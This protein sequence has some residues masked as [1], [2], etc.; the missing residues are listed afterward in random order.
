MKNE[1]L[2]KIAASYNVAEDQIPAILNAL[3]IKT[4]DPN[5]IQLKGFGQVCQLMKEGTSLERAAQAVTAEAK[6]KATAK[7][8][9]EPSQKLSVTER[10]KQ[11]REIGLRHRISDERIPEILAA[12]KL[13][14]EVLTDEQ[15]ERFRD[16]CKLLESGVALN[17]ACQSTGKNIPSEAKAKSVAKS[18]SASTA[19]SKAEGQGDAELVV[20]AKNDIAA[21]ASQFSESIPQD[22][23]EA[24]AQFP[25]EDAQ[26]V[27]LKSPGIISDAIEVAHETTEEGL[28]NF[29]QQEWYDEYSKGVR[30][31]DFGRQVREMLAQGKSQR[32]SEDS[33]T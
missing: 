20:A 28:T 19:I 16:V 31:P 33:S 6:A 21:P 32:N 26:A 24:I 10:E 23:R 29:V 2:K 15:V 9:P 3:S 27:V 13:K 22:M 18:A 25:R 11:L 17:M 12:M 5:E 14:L 7:D 30:D 1:V 8:N 4:E